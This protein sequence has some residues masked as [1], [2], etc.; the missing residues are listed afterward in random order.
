[1]KTAEAGTWQWRLDQLQ[2]QP[3]PLLMNGNSCEAIL[4][5]NMMVI[6]SMFVKNGLQISPWSVLFGLEKWLKEFLRSRQVTPISP[7][8]VEYTQVTSRLSIHMMLIE[9]KEVDNTLYKS[10]TFWKKSCE[11]LW[12]GCRWKIFCR[13]GKRPDHL[14]QPVEGDIRSILLK[15][16][17][18][19]HWKRVI[20]VARR[21]LRGNRQ[22]RLHGKR[23][24]LLTL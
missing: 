7:E 18:R 1:M 14:L 22:H 12:S 23:G 6:V 10:S 11:T 5:T 2:G 24:A 16:F 15:S 17:W 8:E 3:Q 19:K 20:A 21:N 13:H 9:S 4:T